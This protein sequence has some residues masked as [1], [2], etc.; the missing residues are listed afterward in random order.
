MLCWLEMKVVILYRQNSE[1]ARDV[2][3]FIHEFQ[4]GHN[5]D[6]LESLNA[7]SRDGVSTAELYDITE[8]PTLIAMADDGSMLKTWSGLPLPLQNE[9]AYYTM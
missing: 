1:H 3:A 5:G 2:E 6:K 7:D 4:K 8:F 9:V